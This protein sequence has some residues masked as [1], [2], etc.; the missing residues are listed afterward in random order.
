MEFFFSNDPQE[1]ENEI[2]K[3]ECFRHYFP[4]LM[5]ENDDTNYVLFDSNNRNKIKIIK[6]KPNDKIVGPIDKMLNKAKVFAKEIAFAVRNPK[7][8]IEVGAGVTHNATDISTNATRFATK[9][10]I[11][12]GT[13]PK[14][15]EE[16]GSENGAFRHAL[17]QAA[18]TA[19]FGKV[20]AVKAGNAHEVNP[21][22]DLTKR[23][24][25]YLENADQT[26]DLLNN[27]IGRA[28]GENNRGKNMKQLALIL[29]DE[30][31]NN[32]LYVSEKDESG[33]YN[34]KKKQITEE[35]YDSLKSKYDNVD[36]NCLTEEDYIRIDKENK[37]KI[38]Q[39]QISWGTMK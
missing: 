23:Q 35:K 3:Q 37:Q 27:N 33:V 30:F 32:G 22:I 14:S 15:E 21:E 20:H 11:L 16:L 17:W 5:G 39:M 34:V 9:G 1:I 2:K 28:I 7:V 29:L 31:K 25:N 4:K 38:E 24:F 8:A 19:K 18:I 26:T 13:K 10:N 6:A 36:E 12:Y